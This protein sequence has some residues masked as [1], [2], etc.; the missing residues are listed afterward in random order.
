MALARLNN[1]YL[2]FKDDATT[3]I[4]GRRLRDWRRTQETGGKWGKEKLAELQILVQKA[5]FA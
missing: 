2:A 5:A 3:R 1:T 4:A